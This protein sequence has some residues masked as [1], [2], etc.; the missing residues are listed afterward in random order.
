MYVLTPQRVV[1]TATRAIYLDCMYIRLNCYRFGWNNCIRWCD[2]E[3]ME[4][5]FDHSNVIDRC[6][7]VFFDGFTAHIYRPARARVPIRATRALTVLIP[8]GI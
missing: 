4:E 3:I 5:A 8:A 1:H 6:A 7:F 2:S